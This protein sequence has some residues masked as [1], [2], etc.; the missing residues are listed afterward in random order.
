MIRR[1]N[2]E[3]ISF[4]LL[5]PLV[6]ITL[7]ISLYFVFTKAR[8]SRGS[9]GRGRARGEA[10]A[11]EGGTCLGEGWGGGAGGQADPPVVEQY[12]DSRS[13]VGKAGSVPG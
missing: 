10:R 2:A 8:M 7:F 11:W 9:D 3:R 13:W 4:W 5:P 6:V 1:P 12:Q